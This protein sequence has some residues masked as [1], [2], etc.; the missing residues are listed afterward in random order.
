M[1][2][3][4]TA[5]TW[6]V[7]RRRFSGQHVEAVERSTGNSH[8]HKHQRSGKA[9]VAAELLPDGRHVRRCEREERLPVELIQARW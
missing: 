5:R 9:V 7:C 2:G 3:G 4:E 6:A 1:D 8:E